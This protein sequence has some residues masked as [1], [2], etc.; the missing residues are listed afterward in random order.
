MILVFAVLTLTVALVT[1]AGAVQSPP[2]CNANT[3]NLTLSR[4]AG[5]AVP[6][7]TVTF[8]VTVA[9]PLF[10]GA[11]VPA[12]DTTGVTITA[13]CP[14]ADNNI[15]PS[16]PE[17]TLV[18]GA[19]YPAGTAA[20]PVGSIDC[21]MPEVPANKAISAYSQADGLLLDTDL[22][23][24]SEFTRSNA[25]TVTV[26]P[27]SVKVDKQ[28]SCDGGV[29]WVD[30]GLVTNNE[31]GT[32]D[33]SV[34]G[35]SGPVQVRYQAANTSQSCVLRD[36][37]LTES[38][39]TFG[40]PPAVGVINPGTQTEF[41]P[42]E[43]SPACSDAYGNPQTPNEPNT[44]T[45]TCQTGQVDNQGTPKSASDT[46]SFDCL[47]VDAT[48]DRAVNCGTGFVD[49]TQV[50]A[51]EDSTN[52]C[53][54]INGQPVNWQY[55]ACNAGTAL[56]YDCTLV[57]QNTTVSGPIVV[58][59]LTAGACSANLPATGNPQLCSDALEASEAPDNGKVTL[60]C[61]TQDVDGVANCAAA[62][63]IAVFDVSKVTCLSDCDVR[64]DKQ[65]SCD[66]GLN[67]VDPGLVNDNE[68]NTNGC[69][70]LSY[71]QIKVRYQVQNLST[72]QAADGCV[73][74]D[75]NT[76]FGDPADPGTIPPNTTSDYISGVVS[77][78]CSSAEG[79]EPNTATV[80]C[81]S[82]GGVARPDDPKLTA[83]DSA[84]FACLTAALKVDRAVSCVDGVPA[85]FNDQM[86]VTAN[87][88][89]TNGPSTL[90]GK[91]CTWQYQVNN[92]GTAPLY[93]CV[94][95]DTDLLVTPAQIE[96]GNLAAGALQPIPATNT[97]QCS[98]ALEANEVP[99]AQ[100]NL[101][102]CT[103]DVA[104][105]VDCLDQDRLQ[106]YDISTATCLEPNLEVAKDCTVNTDTN[107]A[108]FTVTATNTGDVNLVNCA[109]T[110]AL[111]TGGLCPPSGSS[112]PQTL[113]PD[114]TFDLAAPSG[115][116]ELTGGA[117][118][119][120]DSCN[121]VSVTCYNAI[122]S[123]AIT[124]TDTADCPYTP[125][126]EGCLTR[127]PGF[128]GTHPAVTE[129]YLDLQ[130]CGTTL[131]N[132]DYGNSTSAIEAICSVGKDH[133]ILGAQLTQLVRQCTAAALNIASS[134]EL[135]GNC[136]SDYPGIDELFA[137]CCGADSVCTDPGAELYNV[138][139]CSSTLDMFNNWDPDTLNFDY[140][141]G[142]ADPT[143]CQGA[144][145][146]GIV[147]RPT[148]P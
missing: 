4:S 89:G 21:V 3:L 69:Q 96:V 87:E 135:G 15:P 92:P 26:T 50:R 126:E 44:A 48:V 17:T 55:Q 2:A 18:S 111:Y 117:T 84:T 129:K 98:D 132:V 41:L 95:N 46:A 71:E 37:A 138:T 30:A 60:T 62:N 146:N 142:S 131:N 141:I 76:A 47:S 51:N 79:N 45:V 33:C 27:C 1:S 100:V 54:T 52:G 56:L 114:T 109:A 88:D 116:Q 49:N 85:G 81:N 99:G 32:L 75:T 31:D 24:G 110:D 133:K 124:R 105:I 78:V 108:S 136:N 143:A 128:W 10:D 22:L 148:N 13:Q 83:S 8:G 74:N 127:T 7:Q 61:C 65:I 64:V 144:K 101:A 104:S 34:I 94:L 115:H 73:L 14:D 106:V 112:S 77:P 23:P 140:P 118:L 147:V 43:N 57:D 39:S 130:V 42:A 137:T 120:T 5:V 35:L 6:G 58:G 70:G 36:C 25:I 66:G 28:V 107:E 97:V 53:T 11:G 9:V 119:T 29:N 121:Y 63:Q 93:D 19:S 90:N 139:N 113:I 16:T 72:D 82:C 40:T 102:C 12:C 67:W 123:T 59:N 145:N 86:L 125:K 122:D 134:Q 91:V 38:N 68:D 20:T 103:K 80:T